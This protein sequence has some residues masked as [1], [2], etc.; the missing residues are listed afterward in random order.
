MADK[1]NSNSNSNRGLANASDKTKERVARDGGKAFHEKRGQHGSDS[2][3]Q[4][5]S[6]KNQ[7]S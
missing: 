4:G 6:N 3:D 2:K 5:S 7:K 1:S